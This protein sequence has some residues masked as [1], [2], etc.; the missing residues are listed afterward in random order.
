[1]AKPQLFIDN[2]LVDYYALSALGTQNINEYDP[3]LIT[4]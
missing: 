1:L 4:P 3:Q 2:N